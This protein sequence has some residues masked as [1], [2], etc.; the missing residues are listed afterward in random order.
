MVALDVATGRRLW[1]HRA[2]AKTASGPSIVDGRVLWGY[3]FI[4]FG[5]PGPGGLISFSPTP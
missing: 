3:G 2:P 1:T 5:A 4:L